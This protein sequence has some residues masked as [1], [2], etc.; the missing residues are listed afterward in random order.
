LAIDKQLMKSEAHWWDPDGIWEA[1]NECIKGVLPSA[2]D[3][4]GNLLDAA[5]AYLRAV[6]CPP[7][8]LSP[9]EYENLPKGDWSSAPPPAP[10]P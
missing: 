6:N 2:V 3:E 7:G 9:P 10:D 8:A 1:W 5:A 4:S